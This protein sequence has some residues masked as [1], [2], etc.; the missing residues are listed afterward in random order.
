[1]KSSIIILHGWGSNSAA[2]QAPKR[3]LEN[4]GFSVFV[5][6]LPGFGKEPPPKIPWSV[7]D[8][9][10]FVL[11]Y[12]NKRQIAKFVLIGHSFGGRITIKLAANY[13]EK[14]SGLVLTGVPVGER[15]L[16]KVLVFGFLAKMGKVIF[17][18]PPFSF[19]APLA[20]RFLYF[21]TL[22]RDYYETSGVMRQTF[23]KIINENVAPFLSKINL[24]TLI[25]WGGD[26]RLVS[27]R[28]AKIIKE[29]IPRAKLVIIA[30]VSHKL[31]YEQPEIFVKE[32]L[33]FLK[34][35]E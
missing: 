8:Y 21:L 9:V 12:A 30:G 5:P 26:D 23:L 31:P 25:L 28:T 33:E 19:F 2:W 14:L 7:S 24:P 35:L 11:D 32:V 29:I 10:D 1:M 6:D 22:E 27:L 34:E 3:L 15:N 18:L 17:L 4:A 13:P 20:R 16:I